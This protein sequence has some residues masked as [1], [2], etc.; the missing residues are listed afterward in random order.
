MLFADFKGCSLSSDDLVPS[1]GLPLPPK[2]FLMEFL[3]DFAF[4]EFG[5]DNSS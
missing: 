1:S 2:R 4:G 3:A 5:V